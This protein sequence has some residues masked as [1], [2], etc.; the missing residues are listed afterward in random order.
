[1]LVQ[2]KS[3]CDWYILTGSELV[4]QED[5]GDQLDKNIN[6][7][8]SQCE[9]G[10]FHT[11]SQRTGIENRIANLMKIYGK[12]YSCGILNAVLVITYSDG[13]YRAQKDAEG[14]PKYL[15]SLEQFTYEEEL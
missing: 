1:M 14:Q 10:R 13:F 9:K 5:L 6:L 3:I 12:D 15:R 8:C 7:V 11:R 2:E 4:Y